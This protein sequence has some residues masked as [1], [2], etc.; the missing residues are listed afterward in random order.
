IR[1]PKSKAVEIDG[2]RLPI[3]LGKAEA[4]HWGTDGMI[5]CCGTLLT[6]C[7]Q[8]AQRLREE[9]LDVGVIN[10]R[11]IKPLDADVLGRAIRNTGFV[12]TV[13][14][15][16][17]MTGFGS[18]VLEFANEQRLPTSRIRRL[19]LPDRFIEHA[20]RGELLADLQLD[21]DGIA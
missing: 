1:Y 6:D 3:E 18:A 8:A 16:Q 21:V 10:A 11:F 12:V 17:L 2:E 7:L 5:L 20:D 4:F 19:G 15:G 9:G 14:E 13:E